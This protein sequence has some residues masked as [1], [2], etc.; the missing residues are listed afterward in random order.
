MVQ[1]K[2]IVDLA[3]PVWLVYGDHET[4]QAAARI[5]APQVAKMLAESQRFS[6]P[7]YNRPTPNR[8]VKKILEATDIGIVIQYVQDIGVLRVHRFCQSRIFVNSFSV[9][10]QKIE[11]FAHMDTFAYF[12]YVESNS[13]VRNYRSNLNQPDICL[14]VGTYPRHKPLVKIT[15]SPAV[16]AKVNECYMKICRSQT[17]DRNGLDDSMSMGNSFASSAV[18]MDNMINNYRCMTLDP[19]PQSPFNNN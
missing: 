2:K 18:A 16:G 15:V 3:R 14:T 10:D 7:A 9:K 6:L 17:R 5:H 12:K 1:E 19:L 13:V 11:R 8:F 4:H